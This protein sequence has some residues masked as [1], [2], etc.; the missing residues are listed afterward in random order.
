MNFSID[1]PPNSAAAPDF[2]L[3]PATDADFEF[4]RWLYMDSMQPL[5]TAL[6][7]W[8]EAEMEAAFRGYFIPDEIRIVQVAGRDVGWIQ[9]SFTDDELCL[10]QLH[11][12]EDVRGQ[13]IGTAL[14]N[15]VIAAATSQHKN[16]TL[17][18]VKGNP[19]I[20]LYRRLG[21]KRLSEDKTKI[22]KRFEI[23]SPE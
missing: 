21:F 2:A 15:G 10:D 11:L 3:R 12:T 20:R 8:N 5:L 6:D 1:P 23:R 22:H 14:I 17:S 13:G 7:E 19:A 18:L 16:V 4:A 9:V